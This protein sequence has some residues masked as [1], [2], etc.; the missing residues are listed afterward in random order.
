MNKTKELLAALDK[1]IT[2]EG[3]EAAVIEELLGI[4]LDPKLRYYSHDE[5]DFAGMILSVSASQDAESVTCAF[6]QFGPMRIAQ[7]EMDEEL[8]IRAVTLS[9]VEMDKICALWIRYRVEMLKKG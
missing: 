9:D 7:V 4:K 3:V 8:K 1:E 6:N 2:L 5:D